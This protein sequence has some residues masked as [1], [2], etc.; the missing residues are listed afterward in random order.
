MNILLFI[1]SVIHV[2]FNLI[3]YFFS[4]RI[5]RIYTLTRTVA[6]AVIPNEDIVINLN[7]IVLRSE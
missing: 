2:Q 3:I 4:L 1:D 6:H 5:N 7:F